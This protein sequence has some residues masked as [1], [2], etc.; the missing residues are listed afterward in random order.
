MNGN[1]L[2]LFE[3]EFSLSG[4]LYFFFFSLWNIPMIDFWVKE[5]VLEWLLNSSSGMI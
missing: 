3:L 5:G 4:F 2:P 1:Q